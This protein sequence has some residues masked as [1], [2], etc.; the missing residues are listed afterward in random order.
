MKRLFLLL[1]LLVVL[2]SSVCAQLP[3]KVVLKNGTMLR[4]RLVE[5]DNNNCVVIKTMD[6]S[7]HSFGLQ[8]IEEI[9]NTTRRERRYGNRSFG[10]FLRPELGIG[11]GCS[12]SLMMGV[13][14]GPYLALYGGTEIMK[15]VFFD[16]IGDYNGLQR[17]AVDGDLKGMI[18]G[19]LVYF[20]KN[21]PA[22]F[23]DFRF[24]A[25]QYIHP[26]YKDSHPYYYSDVDVVDRGA[27]IACGIGMTFGSLDIG[28]YG[29]NGFSHKAI[30]GAITLSM[31]YNLRR[32]L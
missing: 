12:A 15:Y 6:G 30:S 21:Y 5:T 19:S 27:F 13:Q 14:C 3:H 1:A 28:L 20:P 23:L 11:V 16:Y 22:L 18:I 17:K 24:G 32:D 4:G 10:V 26:R 2:M 9:G 25:G 7:L 8:D 31:A 29:N